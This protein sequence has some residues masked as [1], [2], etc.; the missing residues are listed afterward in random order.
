MSE[1]EIIKKRI[2]SNKENKKSK[3]Y[4]L[5]MTLFIILSLGIGFLIYARIDPN[6]SALNKLLNTNYNFNALNSNIDKF[7]NG[8]FN[9]NVFDDDSLEVD[10]DVMY[11][12]LEDDYYVYEDNRVVALKDGIVSYV[13]QKDGLYF[14][15]VSYPNN[16][17]ASYFDIINPIVNVNDHILKK[18][19]IGEYENSFKVVFIKDNKKISYEEAIL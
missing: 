16:V 10:G 13:E 19:T 2:E 15:V 5:T 17:M 7:I 6:A 12:Q 1:L 4:K 9:F 14:V 3:L 8:M 11:V 18:S